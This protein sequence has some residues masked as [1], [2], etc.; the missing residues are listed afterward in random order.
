MDI[1]ANHEAD[2]WATIFEE[3]VAYSEDQ[4][5]YSDHLKDNEL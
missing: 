1:I 5:H 3:Q 4:L 2:L